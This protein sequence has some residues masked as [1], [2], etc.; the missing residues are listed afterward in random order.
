MPGDGWQCS[1][2]QRQGP[3][4]SSTQLAGA[5]VSTWRPDRTPVM[6]NEC[7]AN[8]EAD[9]HQ[10]N[11][12]EI[13]AVN[14]IRADAKARRQSLDRL[15]AVDVKRIHDD[16]EAGSRQRALDNERQIGRESDHLVDDPC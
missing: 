12:D 6:S 4:T 8:V 10:H 13:L 5:D 7:P 15:S 14:V 3:T 1:W 9:R 11:R 16:R 2:F